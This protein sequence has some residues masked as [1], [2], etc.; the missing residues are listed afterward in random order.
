[1]GCHMPKS[2]RPSS[3][4]VVWGVVLALLLAAGTAAALL[5]GSV[6]P[7]TTRADYLALGDSVAYGYQPNFDVT[8]GY[9]E[10][11]FARLQSQGS[12]RMVNM[13]CPSETSTS[14]LHGGCR[15]ALFAKTPYL[16]PQIDGAVAFIRANPGRVGPVT[17]TIGANDVLSDLG[18]NCAE[19]AQAFSA[20]LAQFD[21]NLDE[22]LTR[23]ASALGS[24]GDV[25]VTTY[26]NPFQ[27]ACPNTDRFLRELNSHISAVAFRRGARVVDVSS[28]FAGQTCAYTWMCSRFRDIHPTTAGYQAIADRIAADVTGPALPRRPA[29]V[30]GPR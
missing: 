25:L 13:A 2:S 27:D 4:P 8:H 11:L 18:Q 29:V 10:M 28:A 23:L 5:P 12:K 1:M 24:A 20:H 9:V 15:F 26:Y 6:R 19:H 30:R 3:R 17:L 16:G 21:R 14:M 7:V 22:I